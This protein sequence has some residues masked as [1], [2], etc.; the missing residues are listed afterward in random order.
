MEDN[1]ILNNYIKE[2][3]YDKCISFVK[4][5]IITFV[6]KQIQLKDDTI[7]YTTISD[8]ISA[9]D[10]YLKDSSIAHQLN[11]ALMEDNEIEQLN[12]LLD[13]CEQYNIR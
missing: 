3:R 8:L 7:N 2:K 4:D 1:Q 12:S 9:S 6:I 11:F 10:F 5:K 13:I